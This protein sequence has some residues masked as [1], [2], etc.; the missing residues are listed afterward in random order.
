MPY[1]PRLARN[2]QPGRNRGLRGPLL[3]LAIG[4]LFFLQT[5]LVI[6]GTRLG[7]DGRADFRHLYTAGYM[8]RTGHRAEIYNFERETFFQSKIIGSGTALPFDHLAYE[9]LLYVPF[10]LLRFKAAYFAFF[11]FNLAILAAAAWMLRKMPAIAFCC[12]LPVGMALIVGQDSILL[13]AIFAA[14]SSLLESKRD[15][16]AGAVLT[17]GLFKFQY[18]LPVVLL[19]LLWRRWRFVAGA[20]TI[21]A[22]VSGISLV[23]SGTSGALT[24]VRLLLQLGTNSLGRA[25]Q[26]KY[27]TFPIDMPNLRGL[28]TAVSNSSHVV[29]ALTLAI[30]IALVAFAWRQETSFALAAVISMLASYHGLTPDMSLFLVPAAEIYSGPYD[31]RTKWAAAATFAAPAFEVLFQQRYCWMAMPALILILTWKGVRNAD[32]I[33]VALPVAVAP[34]ITLHSTRSSNRIP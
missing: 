20:M 13:L 27:G 6:V 33:P 3:F 4:F 14:A 17:L 28:L 31:V 25:E 12:F 11:A 8:L 18:I 9:T 24:F 16:A 19:F 7:S 26:V 23:I 2:T 29:P 15:F 34:K 5:A 21:G 32:P 22:V 30:S 10:S 1:Y